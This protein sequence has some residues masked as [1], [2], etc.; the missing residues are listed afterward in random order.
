MRSFPL[1][2]K[3]PAERRQRWILLLLLL[4]VPLSIALSV[5]ITGG[6]ARG[7]LSQQRAM[8]AMA[9]Y[10]WTFA[11]LVS[12]GVPLRRLSQLREARRKALIR[13]LVADQMYSEDER[14]FS[15]AYHPNCAQA[16]CLLRRLE[17]GFEAREEDLV[18]GTWRPTARSWQAAAEAE[19]WQT[20]DREGYTEIAWY[21]EKEQA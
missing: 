15:I 13:G 17:T 6:Q 8:A 1:E 16:R 9:C 11:A 18:D 20:L 5:R 12:L 7:E 19:L 14:L 2:K 10:L 4:S 3:T 21:E